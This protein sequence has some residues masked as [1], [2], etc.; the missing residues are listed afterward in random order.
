MFV[1]LLQ[2]GMMGFPSIPPQLGAKEIPIHHE[3]VPRRPQADMNYERQTGSPRSQQFRSQ[4]DEQPPRSG[5]PRAQQFKS[6]MGDQSPRSGSP[7]AQHYGSHMDNR[8]PRTGSPRQQHHMEEPV[9]NSTPPLRQIPINVVG[10]RQGMPL[11]SSPSAH[12]G[13]P[14]TT[15]HHAHHPGHGPSTQFHQGAPPQRMPESYSPQQPHYQTNEKGERIIPVMRV[16]ASQ[17]T[18]YNQPHTQNHPQQAYPAQFPHSTTVTATTTHP[19]HDNMATQS[20]QP[21]YSSP[22]VYSESAQKAQDAPSSMDHSGAQSSQPQPPEPAEVKPPPPRKLTPLEVI[23][24]VELEANQYRDAVSQFKGLKTDK[25][26]RFL[27]EMLM[28]TLLKL[29]TVDTGGVEEVR[30]ARKQTVR[31]IQSMLDE[32]ELKAFAAESGEAPADAPADSNGSHG[33]RDSPMDTENTRSDSDTA[34]SDQS[35]GKVQ[36][37]DPSRVKE[38]VLDSE[39]AC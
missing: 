28:R 36:S 8:P 2:P 21:H 30:T 26:Y 16:D 11:S 17:P 12:Q 24:A 20:H 4:M 9:R 25:E 7:R 13:Y 3:T 18:A 19:T 14:Q 33:N 27:E 22:A 38:M 32:L 10:G 1:F 39:V 34:K 31:K 23:A 37:K 29:D 35:D 6:H 5:S 15:H